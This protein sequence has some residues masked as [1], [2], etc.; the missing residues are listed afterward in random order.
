MCYRSGRVAQSRSA[1]L[2]MFPTHNGNQVNIVRYVVSNINVEIVDIVDRAY[3]DGQHGICVIM[4]RSE[5]AQRVVD[6]FRLMRSPWNIT[7]CPLPPED[8]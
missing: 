7:V 4:A 8:Q 5:T 3:D 6:V 1:V 2:V